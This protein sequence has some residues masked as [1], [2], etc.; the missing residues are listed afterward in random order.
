MTTIRAGNPGF[1]PLAV[2]ECVEEIVG[3]PAAGVNWNYIAQPTAAADPGEVLRLLSVFFVFVTSGVAGARH[4]QLTLRN[5]T[6]AINVGVYQPPAAS[7]QGPGVTQSYSY[8]PNQ[9]VQ[10][11]VQNNISFNWL[12]SWWLIPG[13]RIQ[14]DTAAFDAGDQ[15][16]N[17]VLMFQRWKVVG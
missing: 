1:A 17:I 13:Q 11:V 3:N 14:T 5:T 2:G 16:S 4:I 8:I 10:E 7:T 12:P 6:D 9:P 15:F